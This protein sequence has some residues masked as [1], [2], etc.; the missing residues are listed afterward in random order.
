MWIW[1]PRASIDAA[2]AR[3]CH[4]GIIPS[5]FT[6]LFGRLYTSLN[7]L[8][9]LQ[10]QRKASIREKCWHQIVCSNVRPLLLDQSWY[11]KNAASQW[12]IVY[13]AP[14]R[15][16]L[17]ST[18]N[19]IR[20]AKRL[21]WNQ[22]LQHAEDHTQFLASN[23]ELLRKSKQRSWSIWC[24]GMGACMHCSL[25]PISLVIGCLKCRYVY[26]W[27]SC[28]GQ[29]CLQ[30]C[31]YYST[32]IQTQPAFDII[33]ISVYQYR[34]SFNSILHVLVLVKRGSSNLR[35]AFASELSHF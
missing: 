29:K 18:M 21:Y 15:I 11:Y 10:A 6:G 2:N 4:W 14:H 33:G 30:T 31:S 34:M 35:K 5:H 9:R 3:D 16:G 27:C 32:S 20:T 23:L 7:Y 1:S 19:I 13:A 12:A 26:S 8:V 17:V 24:F 28:R 25:F 22:T